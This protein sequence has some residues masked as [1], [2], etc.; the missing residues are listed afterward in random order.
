MVAF[1]GILIFLPVDIGIMKLGSQAVGPTGSPGIAKS[2]GGGS[3]RLHGIRRDKDRGYRDDDYDSYDND[4]V[5]DDDHRRRR[6]SGKSL[7][8]RDPLTDSF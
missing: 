3:R 2:T 6:S 5:S 7:R 8:D 1:G 4:S